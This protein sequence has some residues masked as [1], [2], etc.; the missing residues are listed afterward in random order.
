MSEQHVA[1]A[2]VAVKYS[3]CVHFA[4]GQAEIAYQVSEAGQLLGSRNFPCLVHDINSSF[5]VLD[6]ESY[7]EAFGMERTGP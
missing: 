5:C 6:S 3:V 2:Q 7:G 1:E 4:D